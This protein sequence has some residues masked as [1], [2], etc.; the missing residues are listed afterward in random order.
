MLQHLQKHGVVI[1]G[2]G[3]LVRVEFRYFVQ[4]PWTY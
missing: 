1:L 3:K 2:L 4:V